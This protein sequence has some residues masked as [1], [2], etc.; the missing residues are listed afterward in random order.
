MNIMTDIEKELAELIKKRD[1]SVFFKNY[2]QKKISEKEEECIKG[3]EKTKPQ[4]DSNNFKENENDK[5]NHGK[6]STNNFSY[7]IW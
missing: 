4:D 5:T 1:N 7:R 2:Y 3:Q 6:R